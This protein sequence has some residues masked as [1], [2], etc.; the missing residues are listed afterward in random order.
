MLKTVANVRSPLIIGMSFLTEEVALGGSAGF[1]AG[2]LAVA[3]YKLMQI[4][5]IMLGDPY[6]GF[7]A[8]N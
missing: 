5:G 1:F 2:Q 6:T 8:P 3:G 4:V 7:I